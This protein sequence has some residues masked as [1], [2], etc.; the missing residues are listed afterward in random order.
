MHKSLDE[1]EILPNATTVQIVASDR[2]TVGN[3]ASSRF[4]ERF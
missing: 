4:L 1:F 2:A 3:T